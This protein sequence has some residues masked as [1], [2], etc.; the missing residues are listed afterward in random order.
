MR[1]G[2][3]RAP[4]HRARPPGGLPLPDRDLIARLAV[5]ASADA[6]DLRPEWP[7]L[8][9]ALAALGIEASTRV[10]TDPEIRWDEFDLVLA[11]GAWDHIH[12]SVEFLDWIGR[13]AASGTTLVNA[14]DVLRWN[15]DKRYLAALAGAGVATVPTTWLTPEQNPDVR[16]LRLPPVEF[17][18][19]P[20]V[21]GGAFQTARYR[22]ADGDAAARAHIRSLL[23]GGRTVMIQP[24]QQDVDQHGEASLVFLGRSYSH[25]ITKGPVL[26][27]GV[28]PQVHLFAQQ[29]IRALEPT[30]AQQEAARLAL[31]AVGRLLGPNPT[32]YA[33]VDLVELA[34]GIPA[35][36][37]LELLDPALFLETQPAAATRFAQVL[38]NLIP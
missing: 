29:E 12:R 31:T 13:V 23:E 1:P 25:A 35:V 36:L 37:E 6:P 8:C 24:Y 14:P 30:G 18:V 34:D 21:S 20:S 16:E 26:R 33:R 5:A 2:G 27:A 22:T 32:T 38:R 10:W 28:G 3:P 9:Q 19:K 15:L 11:N 4:G 7:L 17:V